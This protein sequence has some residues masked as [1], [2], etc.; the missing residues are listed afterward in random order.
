MIDVPKTIHPDLTELPKYLE[1]ATCVE[2][3]NRDTSEIQKVCSAPDLASLFNEIGAAI[4]KAQ[5]LKEQG[6]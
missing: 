2:V 5:A 3:L 6:K 4:T 1:V